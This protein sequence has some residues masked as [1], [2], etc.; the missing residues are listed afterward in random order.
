MLRRFLYAIGVFV[1]VTLVVYLVGVILIAIGN[2]SVNGIAKVG[3]V[4]E[5]ISVVVGLLSGLVWFAN[6]SRGPRGPVG[7]VV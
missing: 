6:G 5:D 7:P 3:R 2:N 1:V 4:V